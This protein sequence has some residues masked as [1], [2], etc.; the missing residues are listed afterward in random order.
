[1][2]KG[3]IGSKIRPIRLIN[4]QGICYVMR[5]HCGNNRPTCEL[6]HVKQFHYSCHC[7]MWKWAKPEQLRVCLMFQGENNRMNEY[8]A[9]SCEC[10]DPMKTNNRYTLSSNVQTSVKWALNIFFAEVVVGVNAVRVMLR[11]IIMTS[12]QGAGR[13]IIAAVKWIRSL[14]FA[15]LR[16]EGRGF[17]VEIIVC[18]AHRNNSCLLMFYTTHL[19]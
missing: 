4:M 3:I 8:F 9:L 16:E 5:S 18:R 11:K 6:F 14:V 12:F 15:R 19:G 10:S 13:E 7:H 1:M 17:T 2:L